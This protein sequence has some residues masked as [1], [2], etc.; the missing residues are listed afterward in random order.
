MPVSDALK[1]RVRC[2]A[3]RLALRDS[4]ALCRLVPSSELWTD[5]PI[6]L[7]TRIKHSVIGTLC[8]LQGRVQY[9]SPLVAM[10]ASTEEEESGRTRNAC[11]TTSTLSLLSMRSLSSAQAPPR[12]SLEPRLGRISE[13]SCLRLTQNKVFKIQ[14]SQ[15]L[16]RLDRIYCQQT[17]SLSV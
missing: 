3:Q 7:A 12:C 11:M 13:S 16:L 17:H 4:D 5:I 1:Q 8:L 10:E 14:V 9:R 2:F 15:L 6:S